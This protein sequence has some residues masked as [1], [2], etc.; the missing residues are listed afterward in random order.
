MDKPNS[1]ESR[2]SWDPWPLCR[3]AAV[4][5]LLTAYLQALDWVGIHRGSPI[6][7]VTKEEKL[8]DTAWV[9]MTGEMVTVLEAPRALPHSNIEKM[10]QLWYLS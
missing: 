7:V 6:T 5:A 8:K 10:R 9:R 4:L 3:L 1:L 2:L